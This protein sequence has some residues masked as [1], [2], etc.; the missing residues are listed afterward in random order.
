MGKKPQDSKDGHR[1]TLGTRILIGVLA[2]VTLGVL[3][4]EWTAPF[5]V[6][7]D[8]YLGLLQMTVLPYIVVSLISRLGALRTIARRRLA[9]TVQWFCSCCG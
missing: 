9:G 4:G 8:I 1:L 7:G 3:L 5:Q 6:V 2:G